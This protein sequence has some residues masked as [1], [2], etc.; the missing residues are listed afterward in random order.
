VN[1]QPSI[2]DLIGLT[3]DFIGYDR[4]I[5][6][7]VGAELMVNI[8]GIHLDGNLI[9]DITPLTGL[10]NLTGMNLMDN[11]ITNINALAGLD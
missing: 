10:I 8:T 1:Y 6:S 4:H 11:Q 3:G 2:D 5:Q 7:I 9:S